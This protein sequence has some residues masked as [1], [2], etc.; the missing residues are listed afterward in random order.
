MAKP[1]VVL[2]TNVLISGFLNPQGPPGSLL[3]ALKEGRFTLV[4][5]PE[6]NEEVLEVANRPKLRDKYGLG[7]S[8]F[9]MAVILWKLAE[10]VTDLP[11][12]KIVSDPDDDKFL[13]AALGGQADYLVTGDTRHLLV[14]KEWRGIQIVNPARFLEILI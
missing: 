13:S 3:K 9:D 8:L 10:V 1:R 11:S 14:L 7:N 12:V 4:T 6:I 5:S 2:D